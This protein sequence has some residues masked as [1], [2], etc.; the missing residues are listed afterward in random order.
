M[1]L[2]SSSTSSRGKIYLGRYRTLAPGSRVDED[3]FENQKSFDKRVKSAG[4]A[5][6]CSWK[7]KEGE[8]LQIITKDLIRNLRIPQ[9]D[10]SRESVLLPPAEFKRLTSTSWLLL[11]EDR[12]ALRQAYQRKKEEELKAAEDRKH[13]IHEADLSRKQNQPLTELEIEARERAQRLVERSNALRMEQEDEI[14]QLNQLILGAQCQA[15]RDYQI[16]EKKQIQM[17]LTEEERRLDSMMEVERRKALESLDK[18]EELR[19]Q[20]RVKG[21]QEIYD[22]IQKRLENRELEEGKKE[23]ESQQIREDQERMNLEDLEVLEKKRMEQ[24]LLQEEIKRINAE[25]MWAKERRIEEEKLVDMRVKEYLLKKQEQQAEYEAE[26]RRIKKEKELEIARLRAQQE[27]EKDYKAEQDELRARRNQD[28]AEREW[29]RKE[30]ERA[31]KKAQLE[32]TLRAAHVEQVHYKERNLSVE[33]SREKAEFERLLKVQQEEMVKEQV[34]NDRQHH[35]VQQHAQ[36]IRQQMKERKILA[37]AKRKE[38]FKEAERLMEEARQ[39]RLRLD[40]L[41]QKKLRE[42]KAT[43]LCEKYCNQVERKVQTL[44]S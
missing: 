13:R 11:K 34:Q 43:G 2:A 10:P 5:K 36:A 41:K 31:A 21:R 18:I 17:E 12:E 6:D 3:L 26:Q 16:Q 27:K 40:E 19:R 39:R 7:N 42:L 9:R 37:T 28:A 22:Q 35:K 25:T 15:K 20:Q 30:R 38:T 1:R 24:Q 44:M 32:A 4:V 8:T 14:K 23:K 29:R 33:A